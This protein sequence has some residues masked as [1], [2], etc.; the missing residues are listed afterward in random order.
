[1]V[2]VTVVPAPDDLELEPPLLAAIAA[3]APPS[4]TA[5]TAAASQRTGF[6]RNT[7]DLLSVVMS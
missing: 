4:A 1:V 2:V 7:C 3:P 6:G 5:V